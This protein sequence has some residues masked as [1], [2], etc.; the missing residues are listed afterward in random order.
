VPPD[1]DTAERPVALVTGGAIR[2][3]AA[4]TSGLLRAGFRVWVHYHGSAAAAQRLA[5]EHAGVVGPIGADLTQPAARRQLCDAVTD[6]KGPAKGRLDL[7]VNN[8]ASFERGRL[9]E[10]TDDDLRR[11]LE[12]NL[13]APVS[14]TRSLAPALRAADTGGVVINV[15]D[16]SALRPWP[17]RLDHSISKAGLAAATRGLAAELAPLRVNAVAPGT[18]LPPEGQ[19][20]DPS[21]IPRKTIGSPQDVAQAV[22]F[23][24]AAPHVSGEVLVLDGGET[25]SWRGPY[26]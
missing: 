4:I 9:E 18:V 13:V 5:K 10:R 17:G 14:L 15:L 6:P 20:A 25:A 7:L 8:A 12:L 21:R 3:G 11:V 22:L 24:A 1:A 16:L 26:G 19:E 23:L 2:V